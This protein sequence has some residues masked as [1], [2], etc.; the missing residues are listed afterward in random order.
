MQMVREA[1]DANYFFFNVKIPLPPAPDLR[2][3]ASFVLD[4]STAP[5]AGMVCD[6]DGPGDGAC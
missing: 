1:G 6:R 3:S 2:D 5:L 4:G